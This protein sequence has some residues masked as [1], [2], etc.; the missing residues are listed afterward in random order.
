[1]ILSHTHS[2]E[3]TFSLSGNDST[4]RASAR[5]GITF[6]AVVVVVV[7]FVRSLAGLFQNVV[8][9]SVVDLIHHQNHVLHNLLDFIVLF[10]FKVDTQNCLVH[11]HVGW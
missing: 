5:G 10:Q 9:P 4:T 2:A 11:F 3:L 1:M 7:V 8:T 6:I